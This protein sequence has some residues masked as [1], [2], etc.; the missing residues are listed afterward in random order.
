MWAA[1]A[2]TSYSLAWPGLAMVP[3]GGLVG[4]ACRRRDNWSLGAAF[5]GCWR[6]EH[7]CLSHSRGIPHYWV[8]PLS[9]YVCAYLHMYV[10]E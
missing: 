1:D 9:S 8:Q 5:T 7:R 2:Q 4:E 10:P 3:L 6:S